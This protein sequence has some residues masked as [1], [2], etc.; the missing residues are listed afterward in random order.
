MDR[1]IER[2]EAAV[3]S[4]DIVGHSREPVGVQKR[5]VAEINKII[6]ER[7][8]SRA[9]GDIVWSS[10]GDGGHLVFR[11]KSWH[12]P[13]VELVQ[14]LYDWAEREHVPLRIVGH[15]G[16]LTYIDGADG[17]VQP[18][19]DGI[20][21]G[22]RLL[23]LRERWQGAMVSDSLHEEIKK[24]GVDLAV[25][26]HDPRFI[27]DPSFEPHL[28]YLMSTR[29]MRSSWDGPEPGDRAALKCAI[30]ANHGWDILYFAKRIWQVNSKDDYAALALEGVRAHTLR[31]HDARGSKK[32]EDQG[33]V[34]PFFEHLG[35]D[36]L[37]E[38]LQLGQ[39][40][41]RGGGDVICR[42]DETGDTMFVIL[43][44]QVGVYNSEGRGFNEATEPRHVL[45]QGEIVGE[46][47]YALSRNRT[48]DL[49][50]L[51]DVALLSFNYEAIRS[52]STGPAVASQVSAY[53][54]FR[55][56]QH[57]SDNAP[58]LLGPEGTGP[59]TVGAPSWDYGLTVLRRHSNLIDVDR[60]VLD[61]TL[62]KLKP[63]G[64]KREGLY[65]LAAG[66]LR[67]HRA[68]SVVLRGADFP[69]LWVDVPNLLQFPPA[70]YAVHEEPVKVLH[71]AA[72]GIDDLRPPQ[73]VA[74]RRALGHATN[75]QT[76]GYKFDIF[77]CHSKKDSAV[78]TEIYRRLVEA[79]I[80]CWF[81]EKQ[82]HPGAQITSMVEEGL[83]QSRYLLACISK[84]F[85]DSNWAWQELRSTVH[86]DMQRRKESKTSAVLVLMLNDDDDKDE[87]IPP[88]IR[89][90]RRL[91]Y[92]RDGD[93]DEL[94]G[95]ITATRTG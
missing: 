43:R 64:A 78:V 5:R 28:L 21:Y 56:L 49:V 66:E 80:T 84:N 2:A 92:T 77:L 74:L 51:S 63:Q 87:V 36:E 34:N 70:T 94:I 54:N 8:S 79:G 20:N 76:G 40:I 16:E 38:V 24:S 37:K 50:A 86:R 15:Y 82:I 31:Y 7:I 30:E 48:A 25:E 59:L 17:R 52:K 68:G 75:R 58:Y 45:G 72:R 69:V 91:T 27:P 23:K 83:S 46:L 57:A 14:R 4:C 44:G 9:S 13:A 93:F 35:P 22:G 32:D 88:L 41:E 53:I 29:D 11:E 62:D 6:A 39:L 95:Y 90:I 85:G 65:I 73:R 10:G 42:Y 26:F 47:A 61:L 71:I 3:V 19:G 18:I 12:G 55:V 81:D 89:D 60:R 33:V 1:A 67:E